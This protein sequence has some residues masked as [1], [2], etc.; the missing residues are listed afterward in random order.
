MF[1]FYVVMLVNGDF[2]E[3]SESS[4]S[5]GT[6]SGKAS[7]P[8]ARVGQVCGAQRGAL[9]QDDPVADPPAAVA[10]PQGVQVRSVWRRIGDSNS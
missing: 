1:C 5:G 6:D 2:V 3:L 4:W 10:A 9:R 7:P 8:I